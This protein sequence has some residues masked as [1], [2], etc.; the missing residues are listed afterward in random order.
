MA[1]PRMSR[2][3]LENEIILT[4]QALGDLRKAVRTPPF[5]SRDNFRAIREMEWK[6][7]ELRCQLRKMGRPTHTKG[8]TS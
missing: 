6:L 1:T 5:S 2:A 7:K 8:D 4:E 3:L